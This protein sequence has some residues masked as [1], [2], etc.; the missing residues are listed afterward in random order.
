VD[1][2]VTE[3]KGKTAQ[4]DGGLSV[5]VAAVAGAA[6]AVVMAAEVNKP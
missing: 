1:P 6:D 4:G 2:T 5:A 3:E